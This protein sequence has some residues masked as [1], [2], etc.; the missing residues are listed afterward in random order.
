MKRY[1]AVGGRGLRRSFVDRVKIL[2]KKAKEHDK[3]SKQQ[4]KV[5]SVVRT[6]LKPDRKKEAVLKALAA[7]L[8]TESSS[9]GPLLLAEYVALRSGLKVLAPQLLHK[10]NPL[11]LAL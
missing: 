6:C 1:K 5:L 2:A 11:W 4:K 7:L 8:R 10:T 3:E 9:C